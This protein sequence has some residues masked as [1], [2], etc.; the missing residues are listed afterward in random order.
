VTTN[1]YRYSLVGF[2]ALAFVVLVLGVLL[3]GLLYDAFPAQNSMYSAVVILLSVVSVW[4]IIQIGIV[5]V[6]KVITDPDGIYLRRPFRSRTIRWEDVCEFG[7]RKRVFG[8]SHWSFYLKTTES[9]HKRIEIATEM[10]IGIQEFISTVFAKTT[11]ARFV[12]LHNV[13]VVPFARKIEI[14]TW[15]NDEI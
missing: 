12:T 8:N 7:R 6:T 14:E 13:S 1:T 11:A 4:A 2:L 3:I 10:L 15:K 5:L 9:G